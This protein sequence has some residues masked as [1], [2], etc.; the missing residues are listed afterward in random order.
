MLRWS[1]AGGGG[2]ALGGSA[3]AELLS[4]HVVDVAGLG[5][6]VILHP[7][8]LGG[9]LSLWPTCVV[10]AQEGLRVYEG[11]IKGSV[12]RRTPSMPGL[13]YPSMPG[14]ALVTP[15]IRR[16]YARCHVVCYN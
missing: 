6:R 4:L 14:N 1:R 7:R 16:P 13:P 9:E 10:D 12:W 15:G 8:L 11:V 2:D 5:G 3:E